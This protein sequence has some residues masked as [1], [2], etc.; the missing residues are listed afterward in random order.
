MKTRNARTATTT[1]R[2]KTAF[3][4]S[5]DVVKDMDMEFSPEAILE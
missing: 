5:G 4:V 1:W 2:A 3:T